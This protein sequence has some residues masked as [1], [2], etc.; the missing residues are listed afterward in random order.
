MPGSAATSVQRVRR[1]GRRSWFIVLMGDLPFV[2]RGSD[3]LRAERRPARET[4]STNDL[5]F[6]PERGHGP[7]KRG[8][9]PM[10][11]GHGPMK[12]G[13]GLVERGHGLVERGHL[14]V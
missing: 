12:R 6:L 4:H 10:K 9:G 14:P 1:R 11:R 7:V 8:H 2:V 3:L 13:H 5:F